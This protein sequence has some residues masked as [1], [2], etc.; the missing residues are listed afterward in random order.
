M[1]TCRFR[2]RLHARCGAAIA[3]TALGLSWVGS[4]SAS[5]GTAC[6][7]SDL[8]RLGEAYAA[9]AATPPSTTAQPQCEQSTADGVRICRWVER[10]GD[11]T[12]QPSLRLDSGP[13]VRR[14]SFGFKAASL[15]TVDLTLPAD[16]Y[17]DLVACLRRSLGPAQSTRHS[18][19]RTELGPWSAVRKIWRTDRLVAELRDP[20]A[21]GIS[22]RLRLSA[23]E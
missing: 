11:R 19:I 23:R 13:P 8:G 9:W 1:P 22:M 16:A 5:P 21:D 20:T 7:L 12:V 10:F 3:A 15:R 17:V 4:A 2:T 14:A 18:T 6:G